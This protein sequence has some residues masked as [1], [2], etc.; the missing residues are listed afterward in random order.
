MSPVQGGANNGGVVRRLHRANRAGTYNYLIDFS[1]WRSGKPGM[2]R[3]QIPGLGV[4]DA[5]PV[6]DSVWHEVAKTL[7]MGL[8][9]QRNGMALSSKIGGFERPA[10][11]RNGVNG[12]VIHR[13]LLPGFF[14]S[15]SGFGGPIESALGSNPPWATNEV[16]D[17]GGGHQDA[18]DWDSILNSHSHIYWIMLD[19]VER[20]PAARQVRFGTPRS[21]ELIGDI[22]DAASDSL[23]D[24]VHEAIW[25]LETWRRTQRN[26]G[27]VFGGL[28]F[29]SRSG[30]SVGGGGATLF[31]SSW[32][33]RHDSHLMA[34]DHVQTFQYAASAAKLSKVLRLFG[35]LSLSDAWLA[36]AEAAWDWADKLYKNWSERHAYYSHIAAK[37]NWPE[38]IISATAPN[39][40]GAVR[41]TVTSSAGFVSGKSYGID[42]VVGTIEAN[43]NL[44]EV[45][46][47]DAVHLDLPKVK[48]VNTYQSGGSIGVLSGW[49]RK[50]NFTP[51][52]GPL[53]RS[54]GSASLLSAVTGDA[55]KVAKYKSAFEEQPPIADCVGLRGCAQWEYLNNPNADGKLKD[56]L[57]GIIIGNADGYFVA[58]HEATAAYEWITRGNPTQHNDSYPLQVLM[59]AHQWSKDQIKKGKYL[60]AMQAHL[61]HILGA[62]AHGRSMVTGLGY[63][64]FA[65]G[66]HA[67]HQLSGGPDSY[68]GKPHLTYTLQGG[69]GKAFFNLNQAILPRPNPDDIGQV[70]R[71]MSEP[72]LAVPL[73]EAILESPWAIDANEFTI[74]GQLVP[75]LVAATYLH[76]HDGN[77]VTGLDK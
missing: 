67:D 12:V 29:G 71:S 49:L 66:L 48:F 18:A 60:K 34:P 54:A 11:F 10:A 8:Y 27:S 32:T 64:N 25:G 19:I 4:S 38:T 70:R 36:S 40:A 68:P 76:A 45:R 9:N 63:R 72:F 21:S 58:H 65:T 46:V 17:W 28:Q 50:M 77:V 14:G 51:D 1:D 2:Y 15:E 74:G 43:G 26:D 59:F 31:E 73:Y 23:P 37:M 44:Q 3:V 24:L 56:N 75:W 35:H 13:S 6:R 62:N 7:W 22:Y 47:V 69:G 61:G 53:S 39:V 52:Y 57:A 16:V 5:F 33:W 42:G 20:V 41:L 30:S 55:T